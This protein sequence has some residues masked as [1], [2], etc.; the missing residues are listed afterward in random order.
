MEK[1]R[2][3][4]P[5]LYNPKRHSTHVVTV[6]G[7]KLVFVSGQVA[8]DERQGIVGHGDLLVQCVKAFENL[9][10]ALESAS[11]CP[12][13]VIKLTVYVRHYKPADMHAIEEGY[14]ACFGSF[15]GFAS[16]LVGVQSLARDGLLI[17]VEAIAA[18]D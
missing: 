11:A 17:E 12:E 9:K 14:H 1:H 8:Y 16:T 10:R 15:R 7:G 2:I 13:D 4:P 5:G 18:V 6:F 3:N